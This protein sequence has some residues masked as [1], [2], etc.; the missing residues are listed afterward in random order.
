MS[1][2]SVDLLRTQLGCVDRSNFGFTGP[3]R[4]TEFFNVVSGDAFHVIDDLSRVQSSPMV[5]ALL[6]A[7]PSLLLRIVKCSGLCSMPASAHRVSRLA[8]LRQGVPYCH[9]VAARSTVLSSHA[10]PVALGG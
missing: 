6:L 2:G 4:V 3:L 8:G 7:L 1:S 9:A 5:Y 10:C